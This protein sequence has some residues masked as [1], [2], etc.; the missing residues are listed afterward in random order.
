MEQNEEL[1][2]ERNLVGKCGLYCG[3]CSIYRAQRD[4]EEWRLKIAEQ[5]HCQSKQ[6]RCNGCGALTSECWG[7]GC[8]IVV[9]LHAKGYQYC[10][11]CDNYQNSTCD[12]YND[13]CQ[14]YREVNEDIRHNMEMIK[15]GDIEAFLSQS[16]LKFQCPSCHQPVAAW[17]ATCK[18]CGFKLK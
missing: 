3:A 9:C 18:R 5:F 8:K 1:Y 13:L 12:K 16:A 2:M 14:D 4:S 11:E 17:S 7:S 10:F 15:N 6:V